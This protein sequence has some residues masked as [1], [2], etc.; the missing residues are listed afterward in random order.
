MKNDHERRTFNPRIDIVLMAGFGIQSIL[1]PCELACIKTKLVGIC[2]EANI[3]NSCAL[4]LSMASP[5]D[6]GKE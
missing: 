1:I 3:G 2:D 5:T 4:D 6:S